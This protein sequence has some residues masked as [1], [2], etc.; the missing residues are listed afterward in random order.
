MNQKMCDQMFLL[1]QVSLLYPYI[2]TILNI[3]YF[4]KQQLY[5]SKK[6]YLR[7]PIW[8]WALAKR[9]VLAI[10]LK[11]LMEKQY[12][13]KTYDLAWAFFYEDKFNFGLFSVDSFIGL[14]CFVIWRILQFHLPKK[15]FFE[16]MCFLHLSLFKI[17]S[18]I[19]SDR[20]CSVYIFIMDRPSNIQT[21]CSDPKCGVY[22]SIMVRPSVHAFS[23]IFPWCK[24]SNWPPTLHPFSPKSFICISN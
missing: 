17:F 13:H 18:T 21:I 5:Q 19:C 4:I 14:F 7:R 20:K 16:W 11:I 9:N 2:H 8:Y 15:S 10:K 22:I 12:S 6:W 23:Q 1:A 3:K 24:Y